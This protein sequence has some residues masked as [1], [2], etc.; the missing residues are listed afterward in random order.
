MKMQS[1]SI[2]QV[3]RYST[4][5]SLEL[6]F[7]DRGAKN[8]VVGSAQ[9]RAYW[10][11]MD[12]G[13]HVAPSTATY[14]LQEEAYLSRGLF[15]KHFPAPSEGLKQL[16]IDVGNAEIPLPVSFESQRKNFYWLTSWV[17]YYDLN[18]DGPLLCLKRTD[19]YLADEQTIAST[20]HEP[21]SGA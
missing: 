8:T 12:I 14:Q 7:F 1:D 10:S 20:S 13:L 3:C 15:K 19:T 5:H 18:H 6:S 2:S 21:L 11:M 4:K 9:I 17:T 16:A